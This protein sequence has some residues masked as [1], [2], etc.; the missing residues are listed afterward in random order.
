MGQKQFL[1]FLVKTLP[2]KARD[3]FSMQ[4]KFTALSGQDRLDSVTEKRVEKTLT[5]LLTWAKTF[6]NSSKYPYFY[7]LYQKLLDKGVMFP[8]PKKKNAAPIFTPS[9]SSPQKKKTDA[10]KSTRTSRP[11]QSDTPSSSSSSS[12]A[13]SASHSNTISSAATATAA[14]PAAA[15]YRD[16]QCITAHEN[17]VVFCDMLTNSTPGIESRLLNPQKN[18]HRTL[19]KPPETHGWLLRV[20]MCVVFHFC[21]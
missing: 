6:E 9:A 21:K 7:E 10:K 8:E 18:A 2:A 14:S 20:H 12:S 19:H 15:A 13:R 11:K 1:D 17:A 3:P 4:A 16:R 5:L